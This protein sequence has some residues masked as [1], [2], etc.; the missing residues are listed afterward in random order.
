MEDKML[1]RYILI[2]MLIVMIPLTYASIKICKSLKREDKFN[3]VV[4]GDFV[5]T[6]MFTDKGHCRIIG[7][8]EEGNKKE[9]LV[10]PSMLDGY[11]VDG[12]GA[13]Y[14]KKSSKEIAITNAK[15]LYFPKN[16]SF[17][18]SSFNF[19]LPDNETGITTYI[20]E[21]SFTN[22]FDSIYKNVCMNCDKVF[23]SEKFFDEHGSI[24]KLEKANVAYYIDE[25]IYFIDDC[26]GTIVNVIPP[27]P[28][29]EGYEFVG[30]YKDINGIDKWDFENDTISKKE[31]DE[32]GN[33]IFNETKIYSKWKK[34]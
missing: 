13:R 7:L 4:S 30:W 8:S 31:Y 15:K 5:Y 16:Y 14:W 17:K 9:V 33:Y 28:Y 11:I 27:V 12:L 2:M 3:S 24:Y 22:Y 20:S 21:S 29:K 10:F 32:E 23:A 6:I 18:Y 1:K 34:I 25:E 19:Q 26:D